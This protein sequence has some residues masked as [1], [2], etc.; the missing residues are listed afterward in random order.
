MIKYYH[1]YIYICHNFSKHKKTHLHRIPNLSEKFIYFNA[2]VP[3]NDLGTDSE[4]G[5]ALVFFYLNLS[6]DDFSFI[7]PVC[8]EDYF[9]E[10]DGFKVYLFNGLT[11]GHP[12][13][14]AIFDLTCPAKF[15]QIVAMIR[16]V[17]TTPSVQCSLSKQ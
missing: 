5:I 10:S 16:L 17:V 6:T 9:D 2:K 1:L 11:A 14:Q 8:P 12:S 3:D 15:S 4:K 13:S 7:N